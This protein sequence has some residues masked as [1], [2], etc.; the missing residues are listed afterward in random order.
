[1]VTIDLI[2]L[3]MIKGK[4]QSAYELQK[5][6]E[7]RHIDRWVKVSIPSIYKKVIQLE[8]KNYIEGEIIRE[9]KMPEKTIY[10]ITESGEKYFLNLMEESACQVVKVLLDFNAVVMNLSLVSDQ[11]QRE[12]VRRIEDGINE[13]KDTLAENQKERQHIPLTGRTIMEQQSYLALALERWIE[14]F[15]NQY[16]E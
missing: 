1:M 11:E 5:N 16:F 8:A 2:V 10:H 9:G 12:L 3:G 15:K 4:A 13:W 7:Y 6:V 14:E